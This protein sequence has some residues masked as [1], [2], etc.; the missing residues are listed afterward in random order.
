M[1]HIYAISGLGADEQV[2]HPLKEQ[3]QASWTNLPWLSPVAE[4]PIREY[5]YR[6]AK[7][8]KHPRPVLLGLS[9]GGIMAIEISRHLQ[10]DGLILISTI[11]NRKELP[12]WLKAVAAIQLH[13][14]IP[15]QSTA[16]TAPIQNYMLGVTNQEELNLAVRYRKTIDPNYLKWA[17]DQVVN[18]NPDGWESKFLHLHGTRDHIFPHRYLQQTELIQEGGHLM[19]MNKSA[20]ISIQINNW[21]NP[22]DCVI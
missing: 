6:M 15:L 14:I 11:K 5:A 9:F 2:F 8:I 3:L 4:E 18:W 19:V 20:E 17:V 12:L 16:L 22:P 13:K 7:Q 21:L 1:K 10:T